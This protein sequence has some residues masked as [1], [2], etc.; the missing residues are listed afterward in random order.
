MS[1]LGEAL[2]PLEEPWP[3]KLPLSELAARHRD[4]L[5]ALSRHG[6]TKPRSPAV[7]AQSSRARSTN[8]RRARPRPA[9]RSNRPT[10]SNCLPPRLPAASCAVPPQPGMRV[11]ILGLLEA[12][13]T[14][15]DRVVL[16][17]L[18]EGTWPPES[19][20][21]AW[22]SRPMRL[23]LGLDLP[24][25]RIGLSAH[26]F[27]Q[28]LGAREVILHARRQDRRRADRAVALRAAAR[29]GRRRALATRARPRRQLSRLGARARPARDGHA[30]A[31]AG[32]ETAARGAA[33]KAF[34]SPRSSTGCAIPTRSTP[35]TS[36]GSRRSIRSTPNPA[37]PSAAR[38]FT[39]RSANSRNASPRSCRPIRRANSSN[40]RRPH[41]AALDDYPEA[42]AFW[43]P[44]F[45]RIAR[46]FARWEIERRA[47]ISAHRRRDSRRNRNP[48][49]RRHVHAARHRRPHRARCRRPLHHPRLQDRLGAHREAGAH[50]A[51]AAAHARSRDAAPGRLQGHS[52]RRL[53]RRARL[54]AAQ[55][56][57][58]ARRTKAAQV[59]GRHAGQPGR[60]R[61]GKAHGSSP[62]ASPMRDQPY[63]SLVHPMWTTHYGDY[64]HLARVKEWSS[65]GGADDETGGGE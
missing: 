11:R 61:A 21:D 47:G 62:S 4:V 10:M 42:R 31:A 57:R 24:E 18:V 6:K 34:R 29:R 25:R 33:D 53:G 9:C 50:R 46:W 58:A 65:T 3:A 22:L 16:G 13:L 55:R 40:W 12:R 49:R 8:W 17:G 51:R 59:Q 48:A 52:A 41:F 19:R 7:T 23:E 1:R 14:E 37:P 36:C 28:L 26:D 44:R 43:W 54:R 15:S 30:G 64:D 35:S 20:T 63:R 56:R 32:A 39:P 38:S 5:A 27:A 60:P 45:E 2:K